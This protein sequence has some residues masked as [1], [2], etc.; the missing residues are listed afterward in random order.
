MHFS[1][2][3]NIIQRTQDTYDVYNGVY[4]DVKCMQLR[5]R[6][7]DSKSRCL[8]FSATLDGILNVVNIL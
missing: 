5:S 1:P 7:N 2:K 6:R 4:D 8:M 3:N